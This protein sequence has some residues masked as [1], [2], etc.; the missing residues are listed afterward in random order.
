MHMIQNK[1]NYLKKKICTLNLFEDIYPSDEKCQKYGTRIFICLFFSGLLFF[2]IYKLIQTQTVTIIVASP[3]QETYEE[4]LNK[5]IYNSYANLKCP[6]S[7]IAFPYR[8]VIDHLSVSMHQICSS[9][10]MDYKWLIFLQIPYESKELLDYIITDAR[11]YGASFYLNLKALCLLANQSIQ[12]YQNQFYE[13]QF[14]SLQLMSGNEFQSNLNKTID[15][16][17]RTMSINAVQLLELTRII[18]HGNQY[19][20]AYF[21]S[22]QYEIR[23]DYRMPLYPLPSRPILYGSNCSCATSSKCLQRAFLKVSDTTE[24]FYIPGMFIGCKF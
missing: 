8:Q 1:L 10:F 16:F 9:M 15:E 7:S 22:W 21:T 14:I 3:S 20:S 2:L 17:R 18:M 19:V 12:E 23:A 24:I 5:A 11:Q 4:L 13:E 6:C